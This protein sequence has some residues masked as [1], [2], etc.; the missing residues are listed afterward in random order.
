[1]GVILAENELVAFE[2]SIPHICRGGLNTGD[3]SNTGGN[4][5]TG[6]G[7]NT[8]GDDNSSSISVS[9][10]S[11]DSDEQIKQAVASLKK[12]ADRYSIS[13]TALDNVVAKAS[14]PMSAT[15]KTEIVAAFSN[16]VSKIKDIQNS[17]QNTVDQNTGD[18]ASNPNHANTGYTTNLSETAAANKRLSENKLVPV[19]PD[20]DTTPINPHDKKYLIDTTA[21]RGQKMVMIEDMS[22]GQGTKE[23]QIT[24]EVDVNNTKQTVRVTNPAIHTMQTV[25]NKKN[26]VLK[27]DGS[28]VQEPIVDKVSFTDFAPG[29]KMVLT[30][31]EMDAGTQQPVILDNQYLIGRKTLTPTT[32][33]G[34]ATVQFNEFD[35]A[36]NARYMTPVLNSAGLVTNNAVNDGISSAQDSDNNADAVNRDETNDAQA[37]GTTTGAY[38]GVAGLGL[39]T[40]DTDAETDTTAYNINLQSLN[41]LAAL[42]DGDQAKWVAYETA[43]SADGSIV[44]EHKDASDTGQTISITHN[45]GTTDNNAQSGLTVNNQNGQ[46]QGNDGSLDS[47]NNNNPSNGSNP[48]NGG[49]SLSNGSNPTTGSSTTPGSQYTTTQPGQNGMTPTTQVPSQLPSQARSVFSQGQPLQGTTYV[50]PS[51]TRPTF[52]QTGGTDKLSNNWFYNFIYRFMK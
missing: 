32:S 15:D 8:T 21:L 11:N 31:V 24:S 10:S 7:S 33:D 13:T 26:F 19:K 42:S 41:S 27:G 39:G 17:D 50:R 9:I 38:Q 45:A 43:Q 51:V 18:N 37:D 14:D 16:V 25:N 12:I 1:M 36:P 49:G 22:T 29:E 4:T 44:A 35:G 47:H 34:V 28:N 52:G 46:K 5:D 6:N 30:A 23:D 2:P 40:D 20:Y 3:G 48:S